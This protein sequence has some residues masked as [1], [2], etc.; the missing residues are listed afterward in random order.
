[1]SFKEVGENLHGKWRGYHSP[2]KTISLSPLNLLNEEKV[3]TRILR[4][5]KRPDD[6]KS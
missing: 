2:G 6:F 3:L 4:L 5:L 1:V